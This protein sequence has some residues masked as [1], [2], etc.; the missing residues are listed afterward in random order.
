MFFLDSISQIMYSV[1][2][3]IVNFKI[4]QV[5]DK[6]NSKIWS[7]LVFGIAELGTS[8]DFEL[9]PGNGDLLVYRELS[10]CRLFALF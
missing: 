2:I 9:H 6:F 4:F 8:F 5:L 3:Y 7:L 10:F 1:Y